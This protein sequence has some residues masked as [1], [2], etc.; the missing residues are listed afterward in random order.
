MRRGDYALRRQSH[1]WQLSTVAAPVRD[2]D[3]VVAALSVVAPPTVFPT[4]ATGPPYGRR[5]GRSPAGSRRTVIGRFSSP[6]RTRSRDTAA[7]SGPARQTRTLRHRR[8]RW[9]ANTSAA[10]QMSHQSKA[11]VGAWTPQARSRRT[12]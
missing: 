9:P 8:G 7:W 12:S 5:R 2:G 1:P 10:R 3:E 6:R 4:Q 11:R